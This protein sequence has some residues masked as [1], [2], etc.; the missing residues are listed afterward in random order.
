[1]SEVRRYGFAAM[2]LAYWRNEYRNRIFSI[3]VP[4]RHR[5]RLF[6]FIAVIYLKQALT[7]AW[8]KKGLLP[9]LFTVAEQMGLAFSERMV[10][11]L[12]FAEPI[13]P[14]HQNF[15]GNENAALDRARMIKWYGESVFAPGSHCVVSAR[16]CLNSMEEGL[17]VVVYH[18][19]VNVEE[20][21]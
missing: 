8:A 3:E 2:Y 10:S 21:F 4:V 20:V 5:D 12:R 17:S 6:A 1:M 7:S 13:G 18:P 9:K 11:Q 14:R 15:T 16:A 19:S